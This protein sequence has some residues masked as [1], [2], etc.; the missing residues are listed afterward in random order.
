[1]IQSSSRGAVAKVYAIIAVLVA[2]VAIAAIGYYL[3]T[4]PAPAP[5]PKPPIKIG[6]V[7][8]LT[9]PSA[10]LGREVVD[11]ALLALEEIN[12]AGGMLGRKVELIIED[13]EGKPDKCLSAVKKLIEVDRVDLLAGILHSGNVIAVSEYVAAVGIPYISAISSGPVL[14]YTSDPKKFRNFFTLHPFYDDCGKLGLKF[15]EFI[16]AKTFVVIRETLT[17]SIR[18]SDFLEL[19][20]ADRG[21]KCLKKIDVPAGCKDFSDAIMMAKEL[22]P[23]ALVFYVFTGAEVTLIKQ[24]YEARFPVPYCGVMALA[25]NWPLFDLIGTA[26]DYLCFGTWSWNISITEKTVPFF[27]KFYKKYGYRASGLEGPAGYDLMY[28]IKTALEKA[29]SLEWDAVI[30]AYE[31]VE[32]IGVRGKTKIDPADHG[33]IYWAPG[34]INGVLGQWKGGKPY[35]IWPPEMAE[36][37]FEKAPW[38]K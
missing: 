16:K 10:Y 1:M 3:T 37:P 27:N 6:F 11:G 28:F 26:S 38:M 17:W 14:V 15:L 32:I 2:I 19:F 5:A 33:A 29:G 34:Y 8:P 9:G 20:A 36:K 12:A 31:E 22:K 30:K 24:L 4:V 18:S 21:I 23:D 13:D 35:A 25:S 7:S